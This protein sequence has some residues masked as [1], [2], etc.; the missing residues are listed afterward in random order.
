[1][2]PSNPTNVV[3]KNKFV[4][5]TEQ[6]LYNY[7]IRS[8]D[9]ILKNATSNIFF[10]FS[11]QLNKSI[12]R[13]Y[14][15]KNKPFT[16]TDFNYESKLNG[17]IVGIVSLFDQYSNFGI[18]DIDSPEDSNEI[19]SNNVFNNIKH[20]TLDVYTY[21]SKYNDCRII[22]TGKN[23]FHI[24]VYYQKRYALP[25]IKN[26]LLNRLS[27][28]KYIMDNYTIQHKRGLDKINLDLNINKPNGGFITLGS[29]NKI[30]L[31][32]AELNKNSILN[33][34]RQS[35]KIV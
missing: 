12:V 2:R 7:W 20:A 11:N 8:K 17:H 32:S 27:E 14:E 26:L 21:M 23:G 24:Y 22:Y 35:V 13:R 9:I 10:Y 5:V 6:D 18:I 25:T 1:M 4:E 28:N 3:I 16:L 29:I 31:K 30:G 19:I 15:E 34:D 33:F